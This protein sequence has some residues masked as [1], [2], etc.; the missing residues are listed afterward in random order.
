MYF[1]KFPWVEAIILEAGASHITTLEYVKIENFHPQITTILP[2]DLSMKFLA[3][4]QDPF[5]VMVTFSSLEHSGLGRWGNQKLFY[6]PENTNTPTFV[7]VFEVV[8]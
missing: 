7:E 4:Q 6:V 1:S 8:S 3:G 5:D 2:E